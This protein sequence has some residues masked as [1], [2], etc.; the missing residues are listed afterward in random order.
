[1]L[2]CNNNVYFLENIWFWM[3]YVCSMLCIYLMNGTINIQY[4]NHNIFYTYNF[5]PPATPKAQIS[6][7][8]WSNTA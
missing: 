8:F 3:I 1:M 6:L 5:P 4:A 2:F 7:H